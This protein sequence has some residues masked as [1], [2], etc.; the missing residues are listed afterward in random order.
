VQFNKLINDTIV[1]ASADGLR[2]ISCAGADFDQITVKGEINKPDSKIAQARRTRSSR[3]ARLTSAS[4][5]F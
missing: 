5:S 3:A 4:Q 2:L 1:T